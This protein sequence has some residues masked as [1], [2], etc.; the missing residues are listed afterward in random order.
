VTLREETTNVGLVTT[1]A[2]LFLVA[3]GIKAAVFPLF[4]WLPA[5]YH[6]PPAAVSAIFAGLL[7]KV[8]VYALIRVFTLL[9]VQDVGYTHTLIL[10]VA[11]LTMVTGV[12]GAIAQLEFRRVLSFQVIST[13]GYMLMG[14]GI[15]TPLAL[16]ASVFYII[17]DAAVKTNL[18]LIS[19][20]TQRLRGT[21]SLA[22]LGGLSGRSPLLA[23]LFFIP[24]M[25]LAG[26]PPL[27]GFF[28]KLALVEAGL[29][30][31]E[32]AIVAVALV[33]STLT[34]L[35]MAKLWAEV[36]W[37]PDP[38]GKDDPSAEEESAR[39]AVTHRITSRNECWGLL[40]PIAALALITVALGLAAE[41]VFA[42]SQR[43]ADQ[44]MDPS[45]YIEVVLGERT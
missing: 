28:A 43:A 41:P 18:F 36:F 33:V 19:G 2:M 1:V 35:S 6:T 9:F 3:F 22:R 25:S 38:A 7:T 42:L 17:Q 15:L 34:L 16:T 24:A 26:I 13:I 4:F 39:T 14:L 29:L 8:G 12:L 45:T 44:L 37:K 27:S 23:V 10:I 31:E 20:V 11:A 5:S 30:T 32:Y 40:G 21:D